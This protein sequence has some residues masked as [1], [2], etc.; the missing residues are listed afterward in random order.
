MIRQ[1]RYFIAVVETGNFSEAGEIC[2]ISQSAISQQIQAL[3]NELDVKLIERRG[4]R[5]ELTPAG[6]YFYQHARQQVNEMDS[7]IREVRRIGRG[8]HQRLRIGVLNGFS[9][10]VMLNAISAFAVEHP[11]VSL[12][13]VTGTHEEIFQQIVAG[14]LDMV[15]NDQRRALSD[16]FVNEF[17]FEQQVYAM[18]HLNKV[19][20][21]AN[22][23]ELTELKNLLCI[24]VTG[25]EYRDAEVA[26][27]R[28]QVGLQ[29]DLLFVENMDAAM[30]NVSAG[31]GFLP[32]DH[33][34]PS[35]AGN[36]RMPIL[37]NGLPFRRKMYAFWLEQNDSSLQ[38]EFAACVRQQIT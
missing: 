31:I 23:I 25:Q 16:Q 1:M 9:S 24:I 38:R 19:T 2:H 11:N 4:R 26:Y 3:E 17:L 37:R 22:G 12:G 28:N 6:R 35:L 34:V 32:C 5:F 14:R 27:W 15:I 21:A 20:A 30:M 18:V 36:V 8:E 7:V 33:D 29:N 13:L 10:L